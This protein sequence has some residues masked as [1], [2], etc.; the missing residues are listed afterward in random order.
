MGNNIRNSF[1][2]MSVC[3]YKWYSESIHSYICVHVCEMSANHNK[4]ID[5]IIFTAYMNIYHCN[6]VPTYR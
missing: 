3:I 2:L 6:M 4:G 1:K 5:V